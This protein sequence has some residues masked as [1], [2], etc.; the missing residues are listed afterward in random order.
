MVGLGKALTRTRRIVKFDCTDSF[1]T[2]GKVRAI[3]A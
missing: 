2:I 3:I 1:P